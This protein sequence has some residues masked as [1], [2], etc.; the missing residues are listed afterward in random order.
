MPLPKH[1]PIFGQLASSHTVCRR[2]S[3]NMFLISP[4]REDSLCARTRI[5][6]GFASFS[7]ATILIGMRAVLSRPFCLAEGSVSR[8]VSGVLM[9]DQSGQVARE[10]RAEFGNLHAD[11]KL[12]QLGD[13]EAR[14]AAGVDG[15]KRRKIH[16]HIKR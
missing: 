13:R 3:R 14:I 9:F 11:A 15:G 7:C 16:S 5:H 4:K 12:T 1:S 6:A 10:L 8:V 2:Y